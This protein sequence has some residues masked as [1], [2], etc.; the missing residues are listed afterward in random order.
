MRNWV[1]RDLNVRRMV[2]SKIVRRVKNCDRRAE[3]IS[4]VVRGGGWVRVGVEGSESE[5]ECGTGG[6]AWV[7]RWSNR[8][9]R[10][11][12]NFE[13]I[14][15]TLVRG[16]AKSPLSSESEPTD[17]KSL[18]SSAAS[19][20]GAPSGAPSAVAGASPVN[21]P[22]SRTSSSRSSISTCISTYKVI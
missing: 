3:V 12:S 20:S 18:S 17:D 15:A 1:Y 2:R 5:S 22:D 4:V 8:S 16:V 6:D 9:L 7:L 19:S 13:I 21:R 14:S 11:A 10:M